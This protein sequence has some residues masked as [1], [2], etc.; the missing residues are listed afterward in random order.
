MLNPKST[1][2]PNGCCH[3]P[4]YMS[5]PARRQGLTKL[6]CLLSC[7]HRHLSQFLA[8]GLLP[9]LCQHCPLDTWHRSKLRK[10]VVKTSLA[11]YRNQNALRKS[12]II[13]LIQLYYF[14]FRQ[15]QENKKRS[16][17]FFYKFYIK[18]FLVIFIIYGWLLSIVYCN[19]RHFV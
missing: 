16:G 7:T 2:D 9:D 3:R 4:I 19:G 8:G 13:H 1:N 15:N 6:S 14:H 17:L 5:C 10:I 12:Y 18:H 11:I